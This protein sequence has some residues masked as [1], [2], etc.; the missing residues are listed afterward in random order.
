MGAKDSSHANDIT[1]TTNL[2]KKPYILGPP[3]A[4]VVK[5]VFYQRGR[6]GSIERSGQIRHSRQH[7]AIVATFLRT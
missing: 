4:V 7:V 5:E 1:V 3:V 6:L 2:M